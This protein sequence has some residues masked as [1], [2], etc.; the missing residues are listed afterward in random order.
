MTPALRREAVE[1]RLE[2]IRHAV[3][4]LR[5]RQALSLEAYVGDEDQQWIV[6]R[7]LQRA[8]EAV[9]DVSLHLCAAMR[10]QAPEDYTQAID[11]LAEAGVLPAAFAADF[12]KTGG[13]RAILAHGYLDVRPEQVYR[14]LRDHLDDFL[15]FARH[16]AAYLRRE[17]G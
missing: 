5:P 13:C 15:T 12:R 17:A 9:L 7:G 3:E 10:L 16:V 2:A 6:E 8:A 11:R 1:K 14:V 4:R